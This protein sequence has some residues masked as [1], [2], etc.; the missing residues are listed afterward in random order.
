MDTHLNDTGRNE[1]RVLRHHLRDIPFTVAWS[2][3]LSRAKEVSMGG[4][5]EGN[6]MSAWERS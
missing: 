5:E 2:S 4:S 1:A 6:E 3:S